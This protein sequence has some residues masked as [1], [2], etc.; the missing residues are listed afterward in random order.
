MAF[1]DDEGPARKP[2]YVI[3]QD[4]SELSLDELSARV[5]AL[6][7]E[8]ARVEEMIRTKQASAAV[9]DTFFRR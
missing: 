3:G 9:A 1:A 6:R 8:V 4:L 5:I 7:A 2:G